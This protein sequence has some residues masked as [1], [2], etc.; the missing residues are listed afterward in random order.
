MGA[1]DSFKL[2]ASE[3]PVAKFLPY[4]H[5]VAEDVISTKSG[6]YV[7]VWRISGRSHQSASD[8]ELFQWVDSLNHTLKGIATANFAFWSHVVR[9]RVYEY[10]ESNFENAFARR[11]D[12]KYRA[13]FTGYNLMVNDL[14]LT[15]VYRP[16]SDKVLSFF[17]K[18]EKVSAEE[19]LNRQNA[20]IKEL[21]SVN[22]TLRAALKAYGGELLTTYEHNGF[23]YSEPLE[24]FAFLVNG[25]HKRMPVAR[26]RFSEYMC[27][28]RPFF[29]NWGEVGELRTSNGLRRFG[30][31]EIKDYPEATEPGHL[32]RLLESDFE[33][34]LAQSFAALSKHAAKDF[35]QRHKKNLIDSNDVATSQIDDIDEALNQL[36]SG[37][38]IMG[39]HHCTLTVF[40]NEVNEVRDYVAKAEYALMDVAIIP[41]KVD[42]AL[43]AGFWAQLPGNF[44]MRPRPAPITSP[45]FLSF[46]PLHNF[47]SGKPAGNPWGPAITILKTVSGTPLYFNFHSSEID[48][49]AEGKRRLGNTMFI[50][51]SGTGKTVTMGFTLAQMLKLDPTVCLF[52]KD[53]GLQVAVLQLGGRYFTLRGGEPTGFNP[54]QLE[55]TPGNMIFLKRLLK[56][57]VG[58]AGAPIT[59]HDEKEMDQA[60]STLMEHIDKPFRRLSMLVQSMPNPIS[61]DPHAHPTVHARLLKWCEGGDY[62]WL[63][64]NAKDGLDLTSHKLYGFDVTDFLENPDIRSALMMYVLYR[65]ENMIDGRRFAYMFDEFQKPLE[66]EY[67]QDLAQNKNRVIRKQNGIFV[68]ATQEPGAV[69]ESPIAKTL[70]QQC[71]TFVFLPN[72]GADPK[73]YIDG[74]K[75]TRTEF[76]LV[77]NLGEASR[78]FL[79]KQGNNSA[80]AELNLGPFTL[81]TEGG[82]VAMDFDDELLVLSGTPDNADLA[83]AAIA[84]VGG[85]PEK[86]LPVY[87]SRVRG[88]E[89]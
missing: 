81:Q 53:R 46:S 10:P 57:L 3:T 30:M 64:D 2:L 71:A 8:A 49:D 45:N 14:Y 21:E 28:N 37:K 5:H 34:V 24:F 15:V 52:D 43:E 76:D 60:L 20:A 6:E 61:D 38:F 77:K 17:A 44:D 31:L 18:A 85:D 42:L 65:T 62:G 1:M 51:K 26:E 35:L 7:S 40:G 89:D 23:V 4:S 87:L 25:E 82:E 22:M 36:M 68:Y 59:H 56:T 50:G 67:F 74:F 84:E 66:D 75:L 27:L 70:V 78:R 48:E 29:S 9:R 41:R 19:K 13:S 88:M 12:E 86:W 16:L 39:E 47:L 11:L 83:E 54:F 79:V 73:E 80:V 72:P 32:N 33:F 69:L 55:P 58:S 63:F